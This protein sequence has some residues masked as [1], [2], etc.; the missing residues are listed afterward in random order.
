MIELLILGL[1]LSL[2]NFRTSIVLGALRL[3]RRHA[4]QVAVVF[5][6]WDMVAP[7]L[8]ILGGAFLARTIGSSAEYVGAA[9]LAG[10]GLSLLVQ[11]WR[12]PE[13]EELDQRWVLFGLPLPLSVDNIIAGTSLGLAGVSPWLA[14]PLFGA[15]TAVMTFVGLELGRAAARYIRLRSDLVTGVALIGMSILLAL[16]VV[17]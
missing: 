3:S 11:A 10:Y 13:P 9:V 2:D 7:L 15:I 6:F 14:S 17:G 5:G 4:V 8:G 16:G 1:T 12:T